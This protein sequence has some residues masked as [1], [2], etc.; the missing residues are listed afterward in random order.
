VETRISFLY[1]LIASQIKVKETALILEHIQ[2]L[3]ELNV[4]QH[5][6]NT[7]REMFFSFLQ[8]L[9]QLADDD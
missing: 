3:Y 9:Q 5:H 8:N 1:T 7:E 6:S 4:S 2:T